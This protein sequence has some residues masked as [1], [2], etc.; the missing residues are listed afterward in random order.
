MN[1][2]W[3]IGEVAKLLDLST[4]ALRYYEKEGLLRVAKDDGN[5]YRHYEYDELIRLMDIQF[6]R[7]MD[8]PVKDIRQIIRER[9]LPEIS[10][11]LKES[12]DEIAAKIEEM[13]RRQALLQQVIEQY[14]ECEAKLGV[15]TLVD[16]PDFN[17]KLL[18]HAEESIFSVIEKIK[19]I[20]ED[21]LTSTRYIIWKTAEEITVDCDLAATQL[22]ISLNR[23]VRSE[24]HESLGLMRLPAGEYLHTVIAT[25]Y[26]PGSNELLAAGLKWLKDKGRRNTG[27][28]LGR[29]LA[30]CH[31]HNLDYYEIWLGV[32]KC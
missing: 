1:E 3:R 28:L 31:K 6:L 18:G 17:F 4:D 12:S 20:D 7:K 5:G 25:D 26:I 30:S 11:V 32:E 13:V 2:K 24:F 16:A 29:Y 14:R 27:D 22:G 8:V 19:V 21:W 23:D 15:F 10:V 9:E